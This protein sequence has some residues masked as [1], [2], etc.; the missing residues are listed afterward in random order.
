ML[1]SF[2]PNYSQK[3]CASHIYSGTVNKIYKTLDWELTSQNELE[4]NQTLIFD[5][6]LSI[7]WSTTESRL[8]QW[9]KL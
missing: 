9:P 5:P 4:V 7:Y 1:H 2:K 6:T 8:I 3:V